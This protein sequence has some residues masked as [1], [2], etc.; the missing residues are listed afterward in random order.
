M[1][2]EILHRNTLPLGGFSGLKEHRLVMRPDLFKDIDPAESWTGLGNFVY[3][4]DAR[5]N[6]SGET[7]MHSHKEVDVISIM[8]EGRLEHKGSLEDG[9]MLRT[10]MVQVQRAGGDGFKHNEIN[11]DDSCNRMLQMWVLPEKAGEKADYK[12]YQTKLGI[13]TRVYG[14]SKKQGD[15]F[16]SKT[17]VEV[18]SLAEGQDYQLDKEFIAYVASG[19]GTANQLSVKEGDLIRGESLNFL[20]QE[21]AELVIVYQ[22]K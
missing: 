22:E 6:P 15:T 5:F 21:G 12:L 17:M 8:L 13:V 7:K 4:A 19:H 20:V 10:G 11:P 16:A 3:L 2:T 1:S 18:A 9:Q 14:G